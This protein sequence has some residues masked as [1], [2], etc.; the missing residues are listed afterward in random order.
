[1]LLCLWQAVLRLS[2]K[3]L[4]SNPDEPQEL[5]ALD[6]KRLG[7]LALLCWNSRDFIQITS[8]WTR[9]SAKRRH[10][11]SFSGRLSKL[12]KKPFGAV[13]SIVIEAQLFAQVL[14]AAAIIKKVLFNYRNLGDAER[15]LHRLAT[16]G[17]ILIPCSRCDMQWAKNGWRFNQ[18]PRQ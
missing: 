14:K 15:S 9:C 3:A 1:M 8:L 7:I 13:K 6:A 16:T 12:L 18:R 11:K 2:I 5:G 4:I 10:L 17:L